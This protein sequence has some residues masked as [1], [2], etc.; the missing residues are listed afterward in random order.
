MNDL[1]HSV[2]S[3][4]EFIDILAVRWRLWVVPALIVSLA[5][6][7]YAVVHRKTWEASQALIVRNEA[8]NN[9]RGLGKFTQLEE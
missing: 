7:I 8:V 3:P 2:I 5:V 4:R 1:H 6:M 9:D